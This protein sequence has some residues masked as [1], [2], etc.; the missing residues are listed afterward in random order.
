VIER[1]LKVAV[2]AAKA[3]GEVLR[4]YFRDASLEIREK[5]VNDFVTEA[6]EASEREVLG[7]IRLDVG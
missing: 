2:A 3:G 4:P 7:V 1:L 5:V 6:D